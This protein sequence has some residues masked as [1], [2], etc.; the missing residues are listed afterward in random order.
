[1]NTEKTKSN[2][3]EV[4]NKLKI[5][6]EKLTDDSIETAKGNLDL[7]SE[8]LQAAY[9]YAKENADKEIKNFKTSLEEAPAEPTPAVQ[10]TA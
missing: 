8:K 10:K 4:K 5:R 2:W 7:L 3:L 9:G 1:M 6:F